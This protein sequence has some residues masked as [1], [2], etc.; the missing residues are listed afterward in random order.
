[1]PCAAGS[2]ASV[3][4]KRTPHCTLPRCFP[5][6]GFAL[7]PGAFQT[8]FR[9]RV[10]QQVTDRLPDLPPGFRTKSYV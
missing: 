7:A 1:M 10:C 3:K 6:R 8:V 9:T 2:P 4:L 5:E